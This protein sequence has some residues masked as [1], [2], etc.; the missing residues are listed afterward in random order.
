[1]RLIDIPGL[2][3]HTKITGAEGDYEGVHNYRLENG[4]YGVSTDNS[5]ETVISKDAEQIAK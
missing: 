3:R 2:K 5:F 1:M 4:A